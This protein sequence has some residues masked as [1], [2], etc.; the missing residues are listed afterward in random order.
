MYS[1]IRNARN[2]P[3]T[4]LQCACF[5]TV[6]Q[7]NP[8]ESDEKVTKTIET[9]TESSAPVNNLPTDTPKK[10]DPKD[11][12]KEDMKWRTPWHQKEAQRYSTLRTFYSEENQTN[13]LK[14]LQTPIDLSPSAIR[15]W[16]TERKEHREM[17]LQMY[18]PERHQ[19][20][21]NELAAAHFIVHRGGAVKFYHQNNW[22]KAN[23]YNDYNLPR[24]YEE[25]KILQAIDCSDMNLYYEGLANLKDLKQVEWLSFNGVENFDDWF[26]DRISNIFSHSLVYLDIRNCPKFT[27]RG[28]GALYKMDNLKILCIDDMLMTT[29][30]EMTC[31]ML[32]E[33]NPHLDIKVGD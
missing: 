5:S 31:L 10:Y 11:V 28:L 6:R 33:V 16:W 9:N 21:G 7:P 26:L 3:K 24:F 13:L 30:F 25:D 29:S 27:E 12:T 2:V 1:L 23:E 8:K 15:K 4:S 32:Q 20:L 18:L 19:T 22:I 17:M 14:F